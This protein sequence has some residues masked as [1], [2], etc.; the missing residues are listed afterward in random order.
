MLMRLNVK[1]LIFLSFLREN[2]LKIGDFAVFM[3]FFFR[4]SLNTE[5]FLTI[6]EK[7]LQDISDDSDLKLLTLDLIKKT[8]VSR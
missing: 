8:A 4:E 6:I 2:C 3:S 1:L 5:Q 7:H